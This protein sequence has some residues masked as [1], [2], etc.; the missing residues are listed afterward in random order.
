MH[1]FIDISGEFISM[2]RD[3]FSENWNFDIII[4]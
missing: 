3:I 1:N 4:E 2:N